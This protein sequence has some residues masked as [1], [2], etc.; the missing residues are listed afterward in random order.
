VTLTDSREIEGLV[1]CQE[2]AQNVKQRLGKKKNA[3]KEQKT[4]IVRERSAIEK[5]MESI[6]EDDTRH[7]TITTTD[8]IAN[9]TIIDYVDI[10]S[11]QDLTFHSVHGDPLQTHGKIK[12]AENSFRNSIELNLSKLK[13]RAYLVGADA[14]VGVHIDSSI[15]QQDEAENISVIMIKTNVTGTAVRLAAPA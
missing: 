7:I 13:K 12:I 14:V 10:I 9:R 8:T 11:V 5:E 6:T 15:D 4:E 2:C 3:V 1:Y